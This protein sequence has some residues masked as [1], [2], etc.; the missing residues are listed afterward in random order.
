MRVLSHIDVGMRPIVDVCRQ[1]S[2]SKLLTLICC[3]SY[4]VVLSEEE[5][6][7]LGSK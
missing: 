6:K 2:C 5:A 7:H 3:T 4:L 1:V